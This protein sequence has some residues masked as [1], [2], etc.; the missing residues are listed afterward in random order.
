MTDKTDPHKAVAEWLDSCHTRF[1]NMYD[2]GL[3]L[4]GLPRLK[5]A[6]ANFNDKGYFSVG[7]IQYLFD[8]SHPQGQQPKY[9]K[10]KGYDK[11]YGN[12]LRCPLKELIDSNLVDWRSGSNGVIQPQLAAAIK[13]ETNWEFRLGNLRAQQNT[14]YSDLFVK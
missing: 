3:D 2:A 4:N 10:H 13:A 5:K 11:K 12:M 9:N 14:S 8:R 6:L 7:E 1:K